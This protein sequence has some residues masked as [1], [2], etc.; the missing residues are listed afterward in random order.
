MK[1]KLFLLVLILGF[2]FIG[3]SQTLKQAPLNPEFEEYLQLIKEGKHDEIQHLSRFGLIPSPVLPDFTNIKQKS[4]LDLPVR[5]DLRD[6]EGNNF[7]SPVKNQGP[8]GTCWAFGTTGAIES[9]MLIS[10]M[11]ALSLSERHIATC[12]GGEW[13]PT[14]GGNFTLAMAY[15]TRR[16][17]IKLD[18]DNPYSGFNSNAT[19]IQGI[20]SFGYS[21]QARLLPNNIDIIKSQLMQYGAMYTS[22]HWDDSYYNS[23]D[24]TYCRNGNATGGHAVT[25][26]GWDDEIETQCGTGAW[27]VKNSW[28]ADWGNDGYFYISFNDN[29]YPATAGFFP[30]FNHNK[31]YPELIEDE[32]LRYY[33]EMGWISSIAAGPDNNKGVVVSQYYSGQDKRINKVGTYITSAGA[34]VDIRIYDNAEIDANGNLI[35]LTDMLAITEDQYCEYPGYYSFELPAVVSA[36]SF[37]FVEI[38]Y[39]TPDYN[40]PIPVEAYI[41]GYVQPLILEGMAWFKSSEEDWEKMGADTDNKYNPAIKV[42]H[43]TSNLGPVAAFKSEPGFFNEI[44]EEI[45]FHNHSYGNDIQNSIWDFGEGASPTTAETSDL[46]SISVSYSTIGE[47]DIKLIVEDVEGL[48]DTLIINKHLNIVPVIID[49]QEAAQNISF[50]PNPSNG[51]IDII[52]EKFTGR[53]N[54]YIYNSLGILVMKNVI[55][56]ASGKARINISNLPGDIYFIDINA[57]GDRKT[58]KIIKNK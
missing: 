21:D 24:Y 5:F 27:L 23:S 45:V 10:E 49:E 25:L 8:Y 6:V 43:Q 37:Y 18:E 41:E 47:K 35:E 9:Y 54:L 30:D 55:D 39:K 13:S 40:Y 38:T 34:S 52:I 32:K 42:Y 3:Y 56:F 20:S 44:N 58:G 7:V 46:S 26:V 36:N 1:K 19:C 50:Y 16:D 31:N 4:G 28:G 14:D 29:Y 57:N 51:I 2:S 15:I 33:D 48:T 11:D 17:G 53:A 12:H 22:M